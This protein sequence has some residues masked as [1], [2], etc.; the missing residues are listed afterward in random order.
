MRGE[1]LGSK[2]YQ[3]LRC[4]NLVTG[5]VTLHFAGVA[6]YLSGSYNVALSQKETHSHSVS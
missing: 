2:E 6:V 5:S 4:G 3:E 1:A